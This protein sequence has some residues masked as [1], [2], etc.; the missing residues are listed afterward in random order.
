MNS[1]NPER[2]L[3][4]DDDPNLLS[5]ISRQLHSKFQIV[6][7]EGGL[8]GL[9]KVEQEG[10]FAVV[11]ADMQMP[12]MNGIQLL[13]KIQSIAPNTVRI[14]LTGNADLGT[15]MHAVNEGNIFR[16]LEK[17]CHRDTL[18]WA[19]QSALEFY[20]HQTAEKELLEKT[21]Y[22]SVQV[23]VDILSLTNPMAFSRAS[24]LKAYS[25]QIA[26]L[27]NVDNAW[28]F[29]LAALLSQIGC[30]SIPADT[31]SKV[32]SGDQLTEEEQK[33][34]NSHPDLGSQLL[35]RI[36]RLD[37]VTAAVSGQ[38][39][40]FKDFPQTE[41]AGKLPADQG[42]LGAQILRVAIDFDTLICRGHN[43]SHAIGELY[44]QPGEYNPLIVWVL[45][46]VQTVKVEMEIRAVKVRDL[47]NSMILAEDIRT[48]TGILVAAEDQEVNLSMRARLGNYLERHDIPEDVR[49]LVPRGHLKSQVTVSK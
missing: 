2:V 16:F 41:P 1:Q 48:H 3:F 33:M 44:R 13:T 47:N 27:L 4:V 7:A 5:G 23:L 9:R 25:G 49:V 12:D 29:E 46:S 35:A 30:V 18:E 36:P 32:F 42:V 19:V 34:Y 37:A 43:S 24:R 20:R 26:K 38:L 22:G 14:M 40:A 10:P 8:E 28:H 15:A 45:K 21:L 31:L 11:V 17:P 6:T 39:K